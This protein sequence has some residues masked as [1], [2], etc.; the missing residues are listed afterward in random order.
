[1]QYEVIHLFFIVSAAV[2]YVTLKLYLYSGQLQE[3]W[4]VFFEFVIFVRGHC[5]AKCFPSK[6]IQLK[7]IV[8]LAM[9][10]CL[11][12]MNSKDM[13]INTSCPLPHFS[14]SHFSPSLP[15]QSCCSSG[16]FCCLNCS[17][18]WRNIPEKRRS[19]KVERLAARE[20]Q[21][22]RMV[23]AL[24]KPAPRLEVMSSITWIFL[25][26][27]LHPREHEVFSICLTSLLKYEAVLQS[28]SESNVSDG[29]VVVEKNH[30]R[31]KVSL[32]NR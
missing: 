13:L 4:G 15:H 2:N 19:V 22:P 5:Y 29:F 28:Q 1:M 17:A 18:N 16:L 24:C 11:T 7:S 9:H 27:Q 20:H 6:V 32:N 10:S 8:G 3:V 12:F 25:Y 26:I 14:P 21:L 31:Q 23:Y 30:L